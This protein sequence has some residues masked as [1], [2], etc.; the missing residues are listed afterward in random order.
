M[1]QS[2]IL[3]TTFRGRFSRSRTTSGQDL[4]VYLSDTLGILL[5]GVIFS[6]SVFFPVLP[7]SL[8]KQEL[9]YGEVNESCRWIAQKGLGCGTVIRFVLL[10]A[11]EIVAVPSPSLAIL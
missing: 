3:S 5:R 8:D 4:F 6:S 1:R 10:L 2:L 9:Y 11:G 7:S